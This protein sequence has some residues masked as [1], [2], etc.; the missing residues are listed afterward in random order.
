M[1]AELIS[2]LSDSYE[3]ER[4][5]LDGVALTLPSGVDGYTPVKGVDYYTDADQ[6]D[7]VQQVITALGTP[8]FGRVDEDKVI[9]LSGELAEGTYTLKYE[10]AAGNTTE[11]GALTVGAVAAYTNQIPIS[12]DTSGSVYNGTGYQEKKRLNSNGV[13]TDLDNQDATNPTFI[14]GFIPVKTGDVIRLKNCFLSTE[15]TEDACKNL[16]G[17]APYGIRSGLYD[18]SKSKV[19]VFSW[20][21]AATSA[22]NV[23]SNCTAVGEMI[24]EFTIAQSGVSYIR[25]TLAATGSP[26]D[27]IVTVNEEIS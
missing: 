19:A 10:D 12:T 5:V 8:V 27:A 6:E 2:E 4:I 15:L 21:E 26:S 18:S 16:Y 20:G 14:T 3:V 13:E 11:I 24:T 9:T 17:E 7:I 25:L 23:I 22:T 1:T